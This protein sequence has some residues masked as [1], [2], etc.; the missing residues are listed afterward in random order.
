MQ[1]RKKQKP[2]S[3]QL[4]KLIDECGLTRYRISQLTGIDQSTLSLFA[5]GQ[6][7][8]SLTAIDKLGELLD[9]ELV[10]HGTKHG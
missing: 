5:S 10:A 3:D 7:R 2:V 1:R 9:I 4:R 6:R 8:L